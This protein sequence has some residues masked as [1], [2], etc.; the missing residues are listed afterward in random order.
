MR[1]PRS[2]SHKAKNALHIEFY[3]TVE[4]GFNEVLGFMNDFLQPGQKY[5]K[6]YGKEPRFNEILVRTNTIHKRKRKIYRDTMIWRIN[7][8][9]W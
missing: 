8:S 1:I 5:G 6:M 7:V 3:T 2:L 9:M 4:P